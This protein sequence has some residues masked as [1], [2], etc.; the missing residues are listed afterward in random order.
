MNNYDI[1][2][3]K[4]NEKNDDAYRD[5]NNAEPDPGIKDL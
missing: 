2:E 1:N 4:S 3:N 5:D